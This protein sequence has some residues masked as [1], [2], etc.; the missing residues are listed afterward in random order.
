MNRAQKG[1]RI[2]HAVGRALAGIF[3]LAASPG[4]RPAEVVAQLRPDTADATTVRL[5]TSRSVDLAPYFAEE[6]GQRLQ[7]V[8]EP[9]DSSLVAVT[10]S[11][12][13]LAV[14]TPVVGTVYVEVKATDA[15]GS[16]VADRMFRIIVAPRSDSLQRG[17]GPAETG[18]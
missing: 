8:A 17:R 3:I 4:I 9:V 11:G 18:G 13:G 2:A 6:D 14:S 5:E 7:Y 1:I 10:M 12:S 16:A 15:R